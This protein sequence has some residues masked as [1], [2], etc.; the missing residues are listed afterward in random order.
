MK[1]RELTPAEIERNKKKWYEEKVRR[2]NKSFCSTCPLTTEKAKQSYIQLGAF[3]C[4]DPMG[5]IFVISRTY[6]A[7]TIEEC[8]IAD[9]IYK[10]YNVSKP[11]VDK[12]LELIKENPELLCFTEKKIIGE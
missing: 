6:V 1:M 4:D 2:W 11:R 7:E 5:E 12:L 3:S 8:N 9:N 10:L